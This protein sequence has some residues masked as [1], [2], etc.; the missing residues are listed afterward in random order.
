MTCTLEVLGQQLINQ[1]MYK[2]NQIK[3]ELNTVPNYKNLIIY[4]GNNNLI[5]TC[6][7][8]KVIT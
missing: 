7:G 4:L 1:E 5:T 6:L 2:Y 8:S 3:S